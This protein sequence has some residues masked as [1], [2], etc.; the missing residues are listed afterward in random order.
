MLVY[1]LSGCGF[2]SHCSHSNTSGG[3]LFLGVYFSYT[4][5]VSESDSSLLKVLILQ[6]LSS[7]RY[8]TGN[9][10]SQAENKK[11]KKIEQCE[12]CI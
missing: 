3:C 7:T 1:E 12:T 9:V 8:L 5:I 11:E 6:T 2:E 4:G 10:Y